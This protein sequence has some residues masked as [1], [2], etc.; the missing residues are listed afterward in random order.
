M[1]AA[2]SLFPGGREDNEYD[3]LFLKLQLKHG[4]NSHFYACYLSLYPY[5]TFLFIVFLVTSTFI[6]HRNYVRSS[7]WLSSSFPLPLL[8]NDPYRG[9][10]APLTCKVAFYIFIQQI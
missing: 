3:D 4:L 2:S 10:T 9:R 6:A 8:P 1:A 7:V 5:L